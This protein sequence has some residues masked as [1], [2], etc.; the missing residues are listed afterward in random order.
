MRTNGPASVSAQVSATVQGHARLTAGSGK[1]SVSRFLGL[2]AACVVLGGCG[3]GASIAARTSTP[4]TARPAPGSASVARSAAPSVATTWTLRAASAKW[5]L[6]TPISREVVFVAGSELVVAGG[7]TT[8]GASSDAVLLLDPGS[9]ATQP[10][11]RLARAVHDAAGAVLAGQRVVFGGGSTSSVAT[12]VLKTTD[13]R[14]FIRIGSLPVPVR[15]PAIAVLGNIIWVFG[16][17]GTDGPT[18]VIQRMDVH[19][20][21]AA[22]AGRLPS[23]LTDASALVL[24]GSIYICGGLTST[25]ATDVIRRFDSATIR[26][27]PAGRL[28]TAR[29]D[30]GSA[31]IGDTGY[32]VGGES[33]ATTSAVVWLRLTPAAAAP[34]GR[35]P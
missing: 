4:A 1:T 14:S 30:A 2:V 12:S 25:G 10:E 18:D 22:G 28:P 27:V 31:V 8:S 20:G 29:H 13:G 7:L 6:P 33:P 11:G 24:H 21:T 15:Y 32:L 23:P 26:T 9:G 17:D 19:S 5:R 34:T 3:S 16:G 35:T